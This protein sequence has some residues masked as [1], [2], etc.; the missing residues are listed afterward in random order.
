MATYQES[1]VNSTK[2]SQHRNR[3][4]DEPPPK[5]Q[6]QTDRGGSGRKGKTAVG[7]DDGGEFN[8]TK[9]WPAGQD[10]LYEQNR[11]RAFICERSE[12]IRE[13]HTAT[14]AAIAEVVGATDGPNAI[15]LIAALR[16]D[17]VIMDVD[18]ENTNGIDVIRTVRVRLPKQKFIV[19]T[20]LYHAT[21]YFH[22][23]TRAGLASLCLKSS[24]SKVLLK[25]IESVISN[26]PTCESQILQLVKQTPPPSTIELTN[27]EIAILV[28]LDMRN[29]EI[30]EELDLNLQAVVTRIER[31]LAKLNQPSRTAAALKAAQLGYILLPKMP[32]FVAQTNTTLEQIEAE[33]QAH[34]AIRRF[35]SGESQ[36]D[37]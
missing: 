34:E 6:L 32:T 7:S 10:P 35:H 29:K 28:R 27:D 8:D 19:A 17:F 36:H 16:P 25:A 18:L 30:A 11:L 14:I 13:G 23:I 5:K 1:T 37:Y 33:K 15:E 22:Q 26:Q 2:T 4:S 3:M 24:G 20:D 9:R 31:I 12:L 21:K